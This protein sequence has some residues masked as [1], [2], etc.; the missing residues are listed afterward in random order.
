MA[1]Q[2]QQQQQ[3]RV[4]S[5]GHL[6]FEGERNPWDPKPSASTAPRRIAWP[7][8]QLTSNKEEA[9]FKFLKRRQDNGEEI[10]PAQ[11]QQL[12]KLTADS[13]QQQQQ[14]HS[15]EDASVLL[16]KLAKKARI[17]EE[18]ISSPIITGRKVANFSIGQKPTAIMQRV[19]AP[20]LRTYR[21]AAAVA[22]AAAAATA[23]TAAA[24]AVPTAPTA[25]AGFTTAG[26]R[27]KQQ[28]QQQQQPQ[29]QQQQQPTAVA[30]NK[31]KK[32]NKKKAAAAA[33]AASGSID[34]QLNGALSAR[35]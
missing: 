23:P 13:R 17:T 35:R 33:A 6:R 11:L 15:S 32:L 7:G 14:Q 2:Q 8:G 19:G 34:Q 26:A 24:A 29:Q 18:G 16:Q 9:L 12:A 10:T 20:V 22:A 21:P 31:N 4:V 3:Q 1:Q 30:L 27:R 28:Q 25:A 5:L